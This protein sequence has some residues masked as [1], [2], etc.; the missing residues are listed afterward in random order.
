MS[1]GRGRGR[2]RERILSRLPTECGAGRG[3]PENMIQAK[4]K[5][6]ML[7]RQNHPGTPQ[8]FL[9]LLREAQGG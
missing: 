2:R 5:S 7:D 4:T 9:S 1:G 8:L 6:Q 3:D